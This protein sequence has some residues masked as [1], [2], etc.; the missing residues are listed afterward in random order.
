M[1]RTQII[2]TAL[3]CLAALPAPARDFSGARALEFTRRAVEF[4]PRP[5]GSP[6]IHKLQAW[7]LAQLKPLGCEIIQDDFT[8]QTP[9]GPIAMKNI[10]ARFKGR[11]GRA[12]VFSGHYDTKLSPGE[13]FVGA[14][15]G[16]SSTGFLLEMAHALSGQARRDDVYLV[17]FDGEEALVNWTADDSLYG[18][19]HLAAR[20]D[21]EA[22]LPRIKALIN[23]DM[24]G[25]ASLDIMQEFNSSQKLRDLVWATAHRLGYGRYFLPQGGPT[26]DDHIPFVRLGVNALDLID[27]NKDYW[28]KPTDTLDKLSPQS[29]EVVGRVLLDVLHQLEQ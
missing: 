3:V 15:D 18:S 11:S 19:R 8:A 12:V 4:G 13:R 6:E 29:F 26:E 27:F 22:F 9:K 14:D 10:I 25:D 7:L 5:P 1:H 20:W 23:V 17:W 24:I 16:G 21:K 28:H 2:L